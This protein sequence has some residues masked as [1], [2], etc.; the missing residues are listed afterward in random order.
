MQTPSPECALHRPEDHTEEHEQQG[1]DER[2]APPV[3]AARP[4][5]GQEPPMVGRAWDRSR[6]SRLSGLAWAYVHTH[7]PG[8]HRARHRGRWVIAQL[9]TL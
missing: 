3:P 7:E 1:C 8:L 2:H 9:G 4:A 5:A 6:C